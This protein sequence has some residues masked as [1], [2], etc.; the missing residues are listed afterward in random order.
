M[1]NF[2]EYHAKKKYKQEVYLV[3][4]GGPKG[5]SLRPESWAR[6]LKQ[7]DDTLEASVKGYDGIANTS[8]TW[9]N[10][11]FVIVIEDGREGVEVEMVYPHQAIMPDS[12]IDDLQSRFPPREYSRS[13]LK[14]EY[15]YAIANLAEWGWNPQLALDPNMITRNFQMEGI[16]Y[17]VSMPRFIDNFWSRKLES[18]S[19]GDMK[20]ED[21]SKEFLNWLEEFQK[22]NPQLTYQYWLDNRGINTETKMT[23]ES[24]TLK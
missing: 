9:S 8:G 16:V 15:G 1:S 2:F 24:I 11:K 23:W 21:L 5:D 3:K 22:E 14:E 19:L 20:G 10:R 17:N 18:L 6:R 7:L 13:F 12:F 4:I